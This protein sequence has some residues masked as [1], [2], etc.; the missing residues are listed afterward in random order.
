MHWD[1]KG[2]WQGETRVARLGRT[3]A[4]DEMV[5]EIDREEKGRTLRLPARQSGREGAAVVSTFGKAGKRPRGTARRMARRNRTYVAG[6]CRVVWTLRL[7]VRSDFNREERTGLLTKGQEP[8]N[9]HAV[10]AGRGQV[11]Q[12]VA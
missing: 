6:P 4:M 5:K 7:L 12:R 9:R 2:P 11:R 3:A 1:V 10:G 8:Q